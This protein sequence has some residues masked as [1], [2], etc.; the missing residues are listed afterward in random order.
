[1]LP[2]DVIFYRNLLEG[3]LG[4]SGDIGDNLPCFGLSYFS[5]QEARLLGVMGLYHEE[6]KK[7]KYDNCSHRGCVSS[8]LN[9]VEDL[10]RIHL[11]FSSTVSFRW[12]SWTHWVALVT[13]IVLGMMR[14]TGYAL[15]P[16]SGSGCS[17]SY[18]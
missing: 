13:F 11:T 6:T 15:T 12:A 4:L 10:V 8:I 1:M 16:G 2:Q 17:V 18:V 3:R 9:T 5:Y 14:T 7:T